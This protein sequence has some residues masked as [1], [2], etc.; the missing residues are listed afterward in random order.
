MNS[1][2]ANYKHASYPTGSVTQW[3]A[4]NAEL[5]GRLVCY[6]DNS[7]PTGK[8]CLAGHNGIDIVAP[9]GTPLLAV[10]DGVIG[11]VNDSQTGYGKHI[12]LYCKVSDTL[13]EQWIY[14]H[15]SEI[16]VKKGQWV[17]K[18]DVIGKM[19]NTGFVVSGATPYW[20]Y[21]P[22]AGT[23]LH[24]GKRFH[25]VSKEY[26]TLV[27]DF[28][29]NG[30]IDYYNGYYGYVDFSKELGE[31]VGSIDS[32]EISNARLTLLSLYNQLQNLINKRRK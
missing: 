25:R 28:Y 18:G 16:L 12:S 19:G 6:S 8:Y 29:I 31:S 11:E 20:T 32:P 13:A 21:N 26:G 5:Y 22:Y 4:L 7:M 15:C 2:I 24:L 17:K 30:V 27:G 1:P 10:K 3:F 23:H 9:W 14:G